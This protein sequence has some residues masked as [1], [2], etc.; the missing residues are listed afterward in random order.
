MSNFITLGIYFNFGTKLSWNEGI[1]TYLNV[2]CVLF[3]RISDFLG[4]YLAVTVRY[5][6]VSAGYCWLLV[7]TACYLSLLL[8]PTF[9]M[10]A[11]KYQL[12]V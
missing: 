9:S 6:V 4:G 11:L 2:E 1:D 7:V 10:I 3:D 8:V 12:S 5:L